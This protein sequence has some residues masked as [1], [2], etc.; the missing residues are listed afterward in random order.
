MLFATPDV[1]VHDLT[2]K[3]IIAGRGGKVAVEFVT[4]SNWSGK[5]RAQIGG[6]GE[7]V[8]SSSQRRQTS[9]TIDAPN[10]RLWSTGR[11]ALYQLTVTL[12][13]GGVRDVYHLEI[14]IR[15]IKVAGDEAL[16]NGNPVFLRGFGKTRTRR[17]FGR[18]LNVP[19]IIRDF[20]LLKWLGAN[21]FRTSALSVQRRGHA[22]GRSIWTAGD[23]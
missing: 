18:A 10:A 4:S 12:D 23:R 14:G 1:H 16:L 2:V 9:L 19:S 7:A 8:L 3:T 6:V 21:S 22:V 17:L 13:D 15:E 11:S 20:E 5:A